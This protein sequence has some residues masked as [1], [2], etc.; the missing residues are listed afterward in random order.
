MGSITN[1][2]GLIPFAGNILDSIYFVL[3]AVGVL[4]VSYGIFKFIINADNEEERRS[5][6]MTILFGVIGIF[7]MTVIWGLVNILVATFQLNN[8]APP[9][10]TVQYG[11]I[12]F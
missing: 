12:N 10:P 1:V 6:R 9:V 4:V 3:T 7:L 5:G 8:S 2:W 11:Q